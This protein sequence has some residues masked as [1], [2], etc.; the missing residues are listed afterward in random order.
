MNLKK[1]L[2]LLLSLL[3]LI[4]LLPM[5]ALATGGTW[6]GSGTSADPF[7]IADAADLLKLAGMVNTGSNYA[8]QY[9]A[10]TN[11]ISLSGDWTPI[12]TATHKFSGNLDGAGHSI[13]GLYIN[14]AVENAALFGVISGNVTIEN[15]SLNNVYI[16]TTGNKAAGLVAFIGNKEALACNTTISGVTV[17]G[18]IIGAE[19]VAGIVAQAPYSNTTGT[20]TLENCTNN[21][22]VTAT[23]TAAGDIQRAGGM[24]STCGGDYAANKVTLTNCTNAGTVTAADGWAGAMIACLN[25]KNTSSVSTA[26]LFDMT[27]C[28]NT[29]NVVGSKKAMVYTEVG[30]EFPT[31][32]YTP[33]RGVDYL[34]CVLSSSY[35][36]NVTLAGAPDETVR[37][38]TFDAKTGNVHFKDNT[39]APNNVTVEWFPANTDEATMAADYACYIAVDGSFLCFD[40]L[41]GA[42]MACLNAGE[43]HTIVLLKDNTENVAMFLTQPYSG[44]NAYY[45]SWRSTDLVVT[46]DANEHSFTTAPFKCGDVYV[47]I[48]PITTTFNYNYT[49][50]ADP[51]EVTYN[52]GDLYGNKMPT[53]TRTGYD[54]GGWY[55]EAACPDGSEKNRSDPAE[56]TTLYAK[57]TPVS[58]KLYLTDWSETDPKDYKS[59]STYTIGD[60]TIEVSTKATATGKVFKGWETASNKQYL[61]N[62]AGKLEI[63][64]VDAFPDVQ[65]LEGETGKWLVLT[66][67]WD[68]AEYTI[69]LNTKAGDVY[70][71]GSDA[72]V[73]YAADNNKYVYAAEHGVSFELPE[74]TRTGY[75]FL[76]W[77]E[78]NT[79]PASEEEYKTS[80][81]TITGDVA[82][83]ANWEIKQYTLTFTDGENEIAHYSVDYNHRL[84]DYVPATTPTKGGH[85]FAGWDQPVGATDLMPA[86]NL[87]VN[88]TWVANGQNIALNTMYSDATINAEDAMIFL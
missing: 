55:T 67:I 58:F 41:I 57:W 47:F 73:T 80:P 85:T 81:Y 49:G 52:S 69:T 83:N 15:L 21:A 13:T 34:A 3:M 32:G 17:S 4:G 50:A 56:N 71:T 40:S 84:S 18:T 70:I 51:V 7:Q 38:A 72:E 64:L 26:A 42:E 62:D 20:T 16:N 24:I 29:G 74:L 36:N 76:G 35:F 59:N 1:T 79:P 78:G 39:Y 68:T 37:K 44:T 63:D 23:S 45:Q 66:P 9:F 46:L 77:Y 31:S 19:K 65:E 88:A 12:G 5:S 30:A 25:Q 11:D 86:E 33:V 22:A 82:L 8:G 48:T 28:N 43:S 10:L 61:L 27:G 60:G 87:T 14:G 75:D 54:F 53:P 6:A 2:A